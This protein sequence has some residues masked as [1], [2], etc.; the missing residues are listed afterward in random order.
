LGPEDAADVGWRRFDPPEGWQDRR[1]V[2][3][4]RQINL[5]EV[6][7]GV[8]AFFLLGQVKV[9]SWAR[10][11]IRWADQFNRRDDPP[12]RFNINNLDKALRG[13]FRTGFDKNHVG[14]GCCCARVF[15]NRHSA[16]ARRLC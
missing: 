1:P 4:S 15:Q 14:L 5:D 13:R 16:S 2:A 10:P 11:F 12:S 9:M 3:A 7:S 8:Q 6:H